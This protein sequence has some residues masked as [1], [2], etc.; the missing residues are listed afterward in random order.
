MNIQSGGHKLSIYN[1]EDALKLE[2]IFNKSS[3]V[4]IWK[5]IGDALYY[6]RDIT[7]SSEQFSC[8]KNL[9]SEHLI[10][11]AFSVNF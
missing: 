6:F 7:L 11:S 10:S 5:Q 9:A 8:I 2:I 1:K 4:K 3:N